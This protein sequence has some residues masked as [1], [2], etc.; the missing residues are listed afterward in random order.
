MCNFAYGDRRM[1]L[2]IPVCK[3][4]GIAEKFTYGDPI[5]HNEIVRIWGLTYA[6]G[7]SPVC[8]R[9]S[10]FHQPS[11]PS[12]S[13]IRERPSH[14]FLRSVCWAVLR[15]ECLFLL[16]KTPFQRIP[17]AWLWN[18]LSL[19]EPAGSFK[20][21]FYVRTGS[22]TPQKTNVSREISIW[23]LPNPRMHTGSLLIIPTWIW[24]LFSH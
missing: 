22:N 3:R 14:S 20:F 12:E 11:S 17:L 19:V 4:S 5:M 23:V 2:G 15:K 24:G 16:K 21:G 9:G 7:D 8:I 1:H 6:Y 13:H 18:E 10:F